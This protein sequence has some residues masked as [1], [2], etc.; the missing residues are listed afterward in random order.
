VTNAE[1]AVSTAAAAVQRF[2]SID[3]LV[4][5]AGYGHLGSSRKHPHRM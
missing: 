3:V 1:Q 5:N 2:G 4:N